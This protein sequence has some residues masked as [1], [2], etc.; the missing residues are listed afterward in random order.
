MFSSFPCTERTI[1]THLSVQEAEALLTKNV[2]TSPHSY[3]PLD[4]NK[5]L[6]TGT[7]RDG[8]FNIRRITHIIHNSGSRPPSAT[9]QFRA[10]PD[11]TRVEISMCPPYTMLGAVSILFLTIMFISFFVAPPS[12]VDLFVRL[13]SMGMGLFMLFVMILGN[14]G[15]EAHW[16]QQ[17]LE[18]IFP[19]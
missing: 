8:H 6:F 7:V 4:K 12:L 19:P 15:A 5:Y 18:K 14:I 16:V 13:L 2:G 17:E 9:G 11:K 10:D 3:W 1:K